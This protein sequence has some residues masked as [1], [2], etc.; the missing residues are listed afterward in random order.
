MTDSEDYYLIMKELPK[1]FSC[2]NEIGPL[3]KVVKKLFTKEIDS[4]DPC[5][6]TKFL[7]IY[8]MLCTLKPVLK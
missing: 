3:H 4:T 2:I 1:I 6:F 5:Y 7:E 8:A